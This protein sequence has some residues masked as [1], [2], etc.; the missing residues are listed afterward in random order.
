[1]NN[2][3]ILVDKSKIKIPPYFP[4]NDIIRHDMAV[5]FSNLVRA[6]RQVLDL[7][8]E[9]KSSGE[10][11]NTYIFF[12]ADHGGPFPRHKRAIYETGTKV[13]LIIKPPKG[14]EIDNNPHDLLSFIDLAPT[15]LSIA[16]IDIPDHIQGTAFLGDQKRES[17]KLLFLVAIDLMN[18]LTD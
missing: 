18:K 11:D 10:Y 7:I 6:D 8:N 15:V 3:S 1:M 16:G 5:N 13:P 14:V 2:D 4:E 9:L 12:Y 17:P